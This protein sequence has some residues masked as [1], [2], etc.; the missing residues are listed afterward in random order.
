MKK[1]LLQQHAWL[2]IGWLICSLNLHT[3]AQV[4]YSVEQI[5]DPKKTGTGYI[6][7]PDGILDQL[8]VSSINSEIARLEKETGVQMAIVIVNDF[9]L[10]QDDFTFA[11]NLFRT[12]KIGAG[13]ADNGLLLLIAK[14]RHRYRFITGY[15]VE[16]L[17]SDAVSKQIGEQQLKPAFR[18]DHYAEGITDA[19]NVI[20]GILTTPEAKEELRQVMEKGAGTRPQPVSWYIMTA[21]IAICFAIACFIIGRTNSKTSLSQG[22]TH[23]L[24]SAAGSALLTIAVLLLCIM[25]FKKWRYVLKLEWLPI[26]AYIFTAFMVWYFYRKYSRFLEGYFSDEWKQYEAMLALHKDWK[27]WIPASPFLLLHAI[28]WQKKRKYWQ[29]RFAPRYDEQGNPL[30]R[31]S[32]NSEAKYLND[33]QRLE[34]KL[35]SVSYDVWRNADGTATQIVPWPGKT[36]KFYGICEACSFHT[37]DKAFDVTIK[38]ATISSQGLGK[39]MRR[40]RK[41]GNEVDM[42]EYII[43]MVVAASA[44]SGS[45]SSSSSSYSSSGGSSDSGSS[46]WGGGDSG[47]GGAGGDW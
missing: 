22:K 11:M 29:H 39:K 38:H 14:D 41:C 36:S 40:C 16:G 18:E 30:Q 20:I 23:K 12:W 10:Q 5:P 27:V 6:S 1:I 15:G 26:W 9:D 8:S 24:I 43:P 25:L 45:S 34:R 17:L 32:A 46:D 7:N 37:L 44:S 42:G 2:I 28:S 3:Y 33:G 35:K 31:V 21:V 4:A 47:G 13:K 19:V